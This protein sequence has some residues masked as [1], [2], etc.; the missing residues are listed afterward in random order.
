M[1]ANYREFW[2]DYRAIANYYEEF[3]RTIN[4]MGPPSIERAWDIYSQARNQ[5]YSILVMGRTCVDENGRTPDQFGNA[6]TIDDHKALGV[7]T[8]RDE[9]PGVRNGQTGYGNINV[10]T[11]GM[12]MHYYNA[13]DSAWRNGK[14]GYHFL[15]NDAWLLGG[16]HGRHDFNLAS[17]RWKKN[18]WD[19][20][21]QRLTATGREVV[22]LDSCGYR[23]R[24]VGHGGLE[25]Y[26][27][28]DRQAAQNSRFQTLVGAMRSVRNYNAVHNLC[29]PDGV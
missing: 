15:Y 27:S 22:F 6:I 14:A 23:V 29:I 5:Q 3:T 18:I 9:A 2:A 8:H 26:T 17:P 13:L 10:A 7:I 20:R 1:Y 12:I 19:S 4:W 25:V 24:K 28:T 21:G 11:G 16:A